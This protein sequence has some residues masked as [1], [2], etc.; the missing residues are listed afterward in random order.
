VLVLVLVLV[1]LV[2]LVL[3]LLSHCIPAEQ[4]HLHGPLNC[5]ARLCHKSG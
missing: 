1:L 4:L 3:L 5:P 2:L